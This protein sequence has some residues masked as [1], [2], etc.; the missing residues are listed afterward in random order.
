M[1]KLTRSEKDNLL[2][3]GVQVWGP[4]RISLYTNYAMFR[5]EGVANDILDHKRT[6][7]TNRTLQQIA[8]DLGVFTRAGVFPFCKDRIGVLAVLDAW[9]DENYP[10]KVVYV[11]SKKYKIAHR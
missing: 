1:E 5:G 7:D 2:Y 3:G 10:V 8:E 11:L 6:K 9:V 4:Y